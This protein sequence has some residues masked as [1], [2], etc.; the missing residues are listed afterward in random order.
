MN[1]IKIISQFIAL[2]SVLFIGGLILFTKIPGYGAI[3][4]AG[5]I[6]FVYLYLIFII[7]IILFLIN[8]IYHYNKG[9]WKKY[10]LFVIKLSFLLIT[11]I[12]S[13]RSIYTI[14]FFG[15]N[16]YKIENKNNDN[17]V[18]IRISL[19]EKGKFFSYTYDCSCETENSGTY[20]ISD[21]ELKLHF[22]TEKPIY[23]DTIYKINDNQLTCE[24]CV[25]NEVL[26]F[27]NSH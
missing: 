24:N 22:D 17:G 25:H 15:F 13:L 23:L 10:R 2:I 20:I 9:N 16:K 14:I 3:C 12:F 27:S 5:Q 18:T 19:Y 6:Y 26:I 21:N 1:K 4:D 7:L 11:L 8:S